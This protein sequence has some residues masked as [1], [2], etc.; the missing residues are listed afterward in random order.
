ME[1]ILA[2]VVAMTAILAGSGL[3]LK[4]LRIKREVELAGGAEGRDLALQGEN[5]ML[6]EQ[7]ADLQ[8]RVG[9]LERIATDPAQRTAREIEML[10]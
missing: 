1:W 8:E 10:R 9:V 3:Q 7:V 4:Q 5:Q 6:R 2:F